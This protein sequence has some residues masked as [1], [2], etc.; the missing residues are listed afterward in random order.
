MGT[1]GQREVVCGTLLS[2]LFGVLTESELREARKELQGE[3]EEVAHISEVKQIQAHKA[4]ARMSDELSHIKSAAESLLSVRL[5]ENRLESFV[6][7][8]IIL[9]HLVA[10]TLHLYDLMK[11][12]STQKTLLHEE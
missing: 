4:E 9:E 11:K 6:Q 2:A 5:R 7:S 10:V 3:I 8:S 1:K 12:T